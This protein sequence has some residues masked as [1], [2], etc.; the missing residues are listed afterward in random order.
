MVD[1]IRSIRKSKVKKREEMEIRNIESEKIEK[2]EENEI[3][4]LGYKIK[5]L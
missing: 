2:K 4:F 3:K 5:F 1:I